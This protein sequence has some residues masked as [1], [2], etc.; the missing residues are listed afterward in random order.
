MAEVAS[1]LDTL[2]QQKPTAPRFKLLAAIRNL[3]GRYEESIKLYEKVVGM[4]K[5]D[6]GSRNNLAFLL[7]MQQKQYSEALQHLNDSLQVIG[8]HPDLLDTK[9][10]VYLQMGKSDQAMDELMQAMD[11][12]PSAM[13]QF[14]LACV[15]KVKRNRQYALSAWEEMKRR[16]LS[17]DD[18]HPLEWP[19][20]DALVQDYDGG[21]LPPPTKTVQ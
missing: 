11:Q 18:V 3:Q 15:H 16:K 5:N 6:V 13:A 17:R 7:A 21:I 1:W 12:D 2:V 20:Y 9:A 8:P 19:A 14:H 10:L 4:D